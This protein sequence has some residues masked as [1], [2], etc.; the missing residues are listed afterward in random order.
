MH[1]NSSNSFFFLL[2]FQ[3]LKIFKEL[4]TESNLPSLKSKIP[5]QQSANQAVFE[6]AVTG[7]AAK[8]GREAG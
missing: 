7:E 1:Q 6:K 8:P 2:G 5:A 3:Y 4:S